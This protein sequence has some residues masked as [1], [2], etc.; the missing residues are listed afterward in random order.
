MKKLKTMAIPVDRVLA[1]IKLRPANL[2]QFIRPKSNT[3]FNMPTITKRSGLRLLIC[4]LFL[5]SVGALFL[6][7]FGSTGATGFFAGCVDLGISYLRAI[8]LVLVNILN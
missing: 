6:L 7:W 2:K 1:T 4:V 8:K 5:V 3:V